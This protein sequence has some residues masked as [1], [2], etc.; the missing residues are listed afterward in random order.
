MPKGVIKCYCGDPFD[1]EWISAEH[2]HIYMTISQGK[3]VWTIDDVP[4]TETTTAVAANDV[5]GTW[6]LSPDTR[7][8]L[9]SGSVPHENGKPPGVMSLR[10]RNT[11]NWIH[12]MGNTYSFV[13]AGTQNQVPTSSILLGGPHDTLTCELFCGGVGCERQQCLY[14]AHPGG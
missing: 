3:I 5:P 9:V 12:D 6:T 10:G 14:L 7:Q 8:V 13:R 4:A 2:S 11:L 1:G